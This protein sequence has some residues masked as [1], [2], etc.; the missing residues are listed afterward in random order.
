MRDTALVL[1]G[2]CL[3]YGEGVTLW[4]IAEL[5]RSAA[6]IG[7]ADPP[8][9]AHERLRSLLAGSRDADVIEPTVV[10][11][12]GLEPVSAT[13][14]EVFS[15]IRLLFEHLAVDRPLVVIVEDIHWAEPT[16]LDLLEHVADWSRGAPILL[17]CAARH[18]LLEARP[19]WGGGKLNATSA[20]LEPLSDPDSQTVVAN[21]LGGGELE[22]SLRRWMFAVTE[23]N[24]LFIEEIVRLLTEDG[25]LR[26]QDERWVA[27]RELSELSV[28][29]TVSALLAARIDRLPEDARE[30]LKRASI[31]GREFQLRAVEDLSP[32]SLRPRV[33][34]ELMAL[35][36]KE[37]IR[38]APSDATDESFRF[39][40]ILIRD[41]A[42]E[43]MPKEMRGSLHERF[44]GWIE[45]RAGDRAGEVEEIVGHHLDQAYTNLTAVAPPGD[46]ERDLAARAADHLAAAGSRAA[47]RGDMRSALKLLPRAVAL[48]PPDAPHRVEH[49]ARLTE[50]L[51]E[52]GDFARATAALKEVQAAASTADDELLVAHARLIGLWAA[53]F[54]SPDGDAPAVR[55]EAE[56]LIRTF[57]AVGDD[58][59][60]AR[61]WTIIGELD[62]DEG[63]ADAAGAAAARAAEHALREGH[64]RLTAGNLSL[65]AAAGSIGPTP[66]PDAIDRCNDVLERL[67]GDPVAEAWVGRHLVRLLAMRGDF[68]E[69]RALVRRGKEVM[70]QFGYGF[71]LAGGISQ[72]AA[73]LERLADHPAAAETELRWGYRIL[74][75]MGERSLLASL[76]AQL[77]MA[78]HAQGPERLDEAE[79]L[80]HV[81]ERTAGGA[82]LATQIQWR[83]ARSRIEAARGRTAPALELVREAVSI[84]DRT[85]LVNEQADARVHL[86]EV[87]RTA[88]LADEARD[89]YR[90]ALGLYE[91]K[92]NAV[93]AAAA[94]SSL[95]G[96]GQRA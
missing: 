13:P 29:P 47:N 44:A 7:P 26:R 84:A 69:G 1:R 63:Q 90:A 86:G 65:Y 96:L 28:P 81:S 24:P 2:R 38:P 42:Y 39:R 48:E 60:L 82:Q 41:A 15:A 80:T 3:T 57:E 89:A 55:Q 43:A 14:E 70:E 34:Q 93:A 52:S 21:L 40:H 37:L 68:D 72:N 6:G 32:S 95:D 27:S 19:G 56:G 49:L 12:I 87:T 64:A 4:P 78:I 11:A 92:G 94:R 9:V 58:G 61:A 75:D 46:H 85:D 23:G 18:E 25:T 59:G 74:T 77:A 16:L 66:V 91:R 22:P 10:Q 88:G 17:I 30:V 50:A 8:A 73:Y 33:R 36:R 76:A 45:G 79:E 53:L 20:T 5:V 71:I 35:L 83:A 62:L 31:V 51:W 54:S 67:A